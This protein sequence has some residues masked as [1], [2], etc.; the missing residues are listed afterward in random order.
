MNVTASLAV[1]QPILTKRQASQTLNVSDATT[2]MV[3]G[4]TCLGGGSKFGLSKSLGVDRAIPFGPLA[5][6]PALSGVSTSL[7]VLSS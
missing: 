4:P 5:F 6:E 3:T 2:E 7:D 1:N